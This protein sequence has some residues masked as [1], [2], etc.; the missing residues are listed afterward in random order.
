MASLI[1]SATGTSLFPGMLLYGLVVVTVSH[2]KK[3]K[4]DVVR[5]CSVFLLVFCV[6]VVLNF[7]IG[8]IYPYWFT[9]STTSFA[10]QSVFLLRAILLPIAISLALIHMRWKPE[11]LPVKYG[12]DS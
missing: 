3:Q 6:S 8:F 4:M 10:G 12:E 2:R 11:S 1:G 5:L 7:A 9:A